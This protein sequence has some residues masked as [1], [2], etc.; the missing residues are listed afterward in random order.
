MNQ[1]TE[2]TGIKICFVSGKCIYNYFVLSVEKSAWS[3][4]KLFT[5]CLNTLL[6]SASNID[7][8]QTFINLCLRVASL[9][10]SSPVAGGG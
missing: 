1:P 7:I 6:K 9:S 8:F 10:S 3:V 2:Y 5:T 4:T